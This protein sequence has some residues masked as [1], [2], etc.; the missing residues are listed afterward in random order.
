MHDIIYDE[1][2]N[3]VPVR[4]RGG[5]VFSAADFFAATDLT[6]PTPDCENTVNGIV[7]DSDLMVIRQATV[8]AI[9]GAATKYSAALRALQ[10]RN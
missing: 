4:K 5:G 7:C 9:N 8:T 2:Y 10:R 3:G 6:I 1:I